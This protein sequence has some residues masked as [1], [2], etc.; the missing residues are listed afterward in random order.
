MTIAAEI[1]SLSPSAEVE[2]FVLDLSRFAAGLQRFHAGTNALQQPVVW[3]GET[4]MPLPIE[5]SG[6]EITARGTLPR[7]KLRVA[8]INGLL[9]AQV[10][11]Y[12]DLVGCKVIRKRT[13]ARYLDAVN[14]PSGINPD[15]DP[16]QYLPDDI[17]FVERKV[18]ENRYVIEWEL[19]SAFDLQG[20]KL[21]ARQV[22]QNTCSWLYRGEQCGYSGPAR[23]VNDELCAPEKDACGKRLRSCIVR[24]TN[25]DG[26]VT[27][28]PFG[29][30]PGARRYG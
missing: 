10:A 13:F 7:P 19:A 4:Y 17:W 28:L 1:Q 12:D 16:N 29:G 8:N 23:D 14:F 30:F 27:P 26:T 15:A 25:P 6:F 24:F 3:Q 2:L 9:S 21:P 20:V 11:A 22:V 18:S 5:A